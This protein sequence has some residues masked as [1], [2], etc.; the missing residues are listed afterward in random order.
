MQLKC[1]PQ[2]GVDDV[3]SLTSAKKGIDKYRKN[4]K[5]KANKKKKKEGG[6]EEGEEEL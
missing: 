6:E 3:H 5:N 1:M 2:T 4:N